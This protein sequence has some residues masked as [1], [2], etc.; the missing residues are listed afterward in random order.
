LPSSIESDVGSSRIWDEIGTHTKLDMNPR[1][2]GGKL[3][4]ID[5]GVFRMGGN[6]ATWMR[7][8]DK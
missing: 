8:Q 4:D 2:N 3:E 7:F 5:L 1:T 6:H